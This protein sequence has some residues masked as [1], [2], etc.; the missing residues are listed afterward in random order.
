MTGAQ[1]K[2]TTTLLPGAG[3]VRFTACVATAIGSLSAATAL[4]ALW[5][6]ALTTVRID[7]RTYGRR[8]ARA[9]LGRPTG[10]S[11][12]APARVIERATN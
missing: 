3:A 11:R 6:P 7:A 10:D 8:T 12:P 1:S 5:R 4:G 9:I 2:V